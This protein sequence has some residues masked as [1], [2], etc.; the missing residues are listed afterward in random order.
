VTSLTTQP[1]AFPAL[2]LSLASLPL[3]FGVIPRNRFYGFRTRTT[4][5]DDG[6]WYRVNRLAG[7]AVLVSSCIYGAVALAMPYDRSA[8]DNFPLW[9]AHLAAFVLPLIAGLALAGWYAKRR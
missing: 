1:F 7:T 9:G 6:I 2:L 3:V 8:P 4:L 5:S